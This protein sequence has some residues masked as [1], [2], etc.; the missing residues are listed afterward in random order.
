M[1]NNCGNLSKAV[2]AVT[3]MVLDS[4]ELKSLGITVPCLFYSE[5]LGYLFQT[6]QSTR[7][8]APKIKTERKREG[9]ER[10]GG[11]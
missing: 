6:G 9:G 7:K 5:F 11:E 2:T 1:L 3:G 4:A 8:Y 10:I